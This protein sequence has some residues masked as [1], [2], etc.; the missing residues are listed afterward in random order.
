[1]NGLRIDSGDFMNNPR[2]I[3]EH[4]AKL[5]SNFE[6]LFNIVPHESDNIKVILSG[7]FDYHKILEVEAQNKQ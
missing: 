7:D 6:Q 5:K 2:Y 4:F 3:K 1:M